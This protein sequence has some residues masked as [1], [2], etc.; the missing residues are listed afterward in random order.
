VIDAPGGNVTLTGDGIQLLLATQVKG[1]GT[2]QL[3]PLTPSLR[4]SVGGG[5]A[6]DRLNLSSDEVTS[7][8][9]SGFSQLIIG[10]ADGTGVIEIDPT[11][12]VE[13]KS[14][15][16][17]TTIQS[18][19][20]PGSIA[21]NGPIKANGGITFNGAT[22][23]SADVSTIGKDITFNSPV[24]VEDKANLNTGTGGGNILFKE[25]V[26][27]KIGNTN[28][29]DLTLITDTGNITFS[30]DVGSVT[31]LGNLQIESAGNVQ[32]KAITAATA[33]ITQTA[34]TGTTAFKGPVTTNAAAA[35]T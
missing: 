30:G 4:I 26:D 28:S 15:N 20:S 24:T 5:S 35:L 6:D 1:S 8:R 29:Q 14:L 25:T 32:T 21:V 13:F 11:T 31:S 27:G 17:A 7:P 19:I 16:T 23:L 3:Q 9:L 12:G 2:I 10:R 34:G 33:S 22:S 18:P